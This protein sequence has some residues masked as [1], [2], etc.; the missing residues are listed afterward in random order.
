MP[1]L[2]VDEVVRVDHPLTFYEKFCTSK[3]QMSIQQ[4]LQPWDSTEE[5]FEY[6]VEQTYGGFIELVKDICKKRD[7]LYMCT[8]G[9]ITV[10]D[11]DMDTPYVRI[12]KYKTKGD[13][14]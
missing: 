11:V 3:E 2:I 6:E 7:E 12:T 8:Y 5:S 9:R 10:N 14:N 13:D 4:D 1:I